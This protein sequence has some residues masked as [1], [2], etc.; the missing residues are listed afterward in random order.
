LTEGIDW[1]DFNVHAGLVNAALAERIA[2]DNLEEGRSALV[3]TGDLA[4]EFLADYQPEHYRGVMHYKLPRLEPGA[5]RTHLVRGL[6]T[7]HRE[8]G[9]FAAWHLPVVQPYAAAVDA[10]LALPAGFLSRVDRK[11]RLSRAV[12]GALLPD[13]IY[14]R[15]KVRA[16]LGS[17]SGDG[18]VLGLCLDRGLDSAAFRRRFAVLHGG[19]DL[20]AL[21]R[22]I[23][24][25]S[26]RSA[27]PSL[28][29]VSS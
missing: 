29:Q 14:E 17:S 11:Q 28:E 6:D 27:I 2:E 4:N 22:F 20:A 3:L 19:G 5:L 1:R 7:C 25:G 24:G 8:V 12:F 15:K 21:D 10:Y 26:Y 23:R 18:G 9:V 13:Y 16:Q